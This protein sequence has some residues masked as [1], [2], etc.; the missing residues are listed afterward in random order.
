MYIAGRHLI[1]GGNTYKPGDT[2]PDAKA[3]P[4][5]AALVGNGGLIWRADPELEL[6]LKPEPAPVE[7]APV[8]PEP[9]RGAF[10]KKRKLK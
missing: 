2:V 5:C 10:F 6:E 9:E 3:W 8:E 4:S 7:T 1:F